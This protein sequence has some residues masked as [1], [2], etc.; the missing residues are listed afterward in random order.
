VQSIEA[1]FREVES[2]KVIYQCLGK[3]LG[4]KDGEELADE[5]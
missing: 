1:D 5:Y 4:G 3:Q 2:R